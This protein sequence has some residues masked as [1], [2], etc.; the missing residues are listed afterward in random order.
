PAVA[1]TVKG[2]I[3]ELRKG[4]DQRAL[5]RA[6]EEL[7]SVA[8]EGGNLMPPTLE[9]IKSLAT[10]GEVSGALRQVFGEW[11]APNIQ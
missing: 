9:A 4:R 3:D 5:S 6:L 1:S 8:N 11:R 7:K 10:V 2:E